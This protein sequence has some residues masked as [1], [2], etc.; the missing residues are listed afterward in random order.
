MLMYSIY[1]LVL[2]FES[3]IK[4]SLLQATNNLKFDIYENAYSSRHFLAHRHENRLVKA[5]HT[6]N[7]FG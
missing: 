3:N 5:R 1:L 4:C 7:C 2:L 6:L